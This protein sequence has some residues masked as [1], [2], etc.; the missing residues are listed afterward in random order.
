MAWY[1]GDVFERAMMRDRAFGPYGWVFWILLSPELRPPATALVAS[2]AH[3]RR[4]PS[5]HR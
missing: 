2:R 3:E 5:T 4:S 1:S